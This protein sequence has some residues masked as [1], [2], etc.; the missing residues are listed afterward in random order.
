MGK[1]I[2]ST[3]S[4]HVANLTMLVGRLVQQIRKYD[5]ENPV[6]E[7]AMDYLRRSDLVPSLLRGTTENSRSAMTPE[8]PKWGRCAECGEATHLNDRYLCSSC[9]AK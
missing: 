1:H 3:D 6:V 9:E 8:E 7:K 2:P 4:Q 5:K